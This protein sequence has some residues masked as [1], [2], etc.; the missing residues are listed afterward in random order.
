MVFDHYT[1][2]EDAIRERLN[3]FIK[4][5]E[6]ERQA[7]EFLKAHPEYKTSS[8][9]RAFIRRVLGHRPPADD[10]HNEIQKL[11]KDAG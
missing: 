4:D 3:D 2:V 9:V 5:A 11:Q 6:R 7:N 8:K 10:N 1:F